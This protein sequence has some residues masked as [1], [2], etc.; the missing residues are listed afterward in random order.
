M[1]VTANGKPRAVDDGE[2][3]S[4]L[5]ERLG[6]AEDRVVIEHNGEPL[7]REHFSQTHLQ[8]GDS[9]EIAQM[10]GGG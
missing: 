10:V 3:V 9:L 5:L 8:A 1:M 6:L 4:G 2:T 7:E